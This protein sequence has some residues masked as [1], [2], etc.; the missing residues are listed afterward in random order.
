MLD[1]HIG[2]VGTA[3]LALCFVLL[4]AGVMHGS[5]T[6][7][8]SSAGGF[9]AQVIGLYTQTLGEWSRPLIGVAAF[10]VMFS[11]TLTVIDGFPRAL[12]TLAERFRHPEVAGAHEVRSAPIRRDYWIALA[13]LGTGSVLVLA[14]FLGSLKAMVDVATT[15]SFLTAP[16]LAILNHRAVLGAEVPESSRPRPWLVGASLVGIAFLSAFAAYYLVLLLTA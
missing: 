14:A 12:A 3:A 13:A 16:V 6:A 7:L 1:F 10:A 5:G 8:A 2:Y 9:A 11:T 4:G 15:L